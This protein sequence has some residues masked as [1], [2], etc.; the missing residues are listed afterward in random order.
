MRVFKE[1][2]SL[3]GRCITTAIVGFPVIVHHTNIVAV[4][5]NV[6]HKVSKAFHP[7]AL[8]L[9]AGEFVFVR[10]ADPIPRISNDAEGN[11]SLSQDMVPDTGFAG[12]LTPSGTTTVI[13]TSLWDDGFQSM[14][15]SGGPGF[16]VGAP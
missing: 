1:M 14:V 15:Y 2:R 9:A 11:R 3:V 13:I 7:W 16:G 6:S 4:V 8:N 12:K 5:M 10:G